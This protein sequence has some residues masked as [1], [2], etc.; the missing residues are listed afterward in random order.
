M[1]E[2]Q[3]YTFTGASGSGKSTLLNEIGAF[4]NFKV[5]ELSGRPYLPLEG[6][7]VQNSS[8][9]VTTRISYGST[10]TFV[11]SLLK[12]PHNNI[13]FSRCAV[14]KLAYV[15]ALNIGKDV[16]SIIIKEIK[17]IVIPHIKVFYLPIEFALTDTNDTVRGTNEKVRQLT[18]AHVKGVLNYY[19]IPYITVKGSVEERI[20]IIKSS[21]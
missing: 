15:R 20:E 12:Y 4:H 18:D 6:D 16:E 19:E 8:D 7:Y 3:L 11:E 1:R 13:F 17:E 21:L 9:I 10:V 2:R 5:V 14:D